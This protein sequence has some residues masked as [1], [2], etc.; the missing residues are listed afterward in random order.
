MALARFGDL[1]EA[2]KEKYSDNKTIKF[3]KGIK[4]D[5]VKCDYEPGRRESTYCE[6]RIETDKGTRWVEVSG[7]AA[8]IVNGGVRYAGGN[9]V[10][11]PDETDQLLVE[12][13]HNK[14]EIEGFQNRNTQAVRLPASVERDI[15]RSRQPRLE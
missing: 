5:K 8:E 12:K 15:A 4:T 14:V 7:I 10:I 13:K 11:R 6:A 3:R 1:K 2:A 9:L